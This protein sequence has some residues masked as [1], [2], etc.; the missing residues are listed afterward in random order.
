[1][2]TC[3]AFG[4]VLGYLGAGLGPLKPFWGPFELICDNLH[5]QFG[6]FQAGLGYFGTLS[7][8]LGHLGPFAG[9]LGRFRG[10]W[11]GLGT[12]LSAFKAIWGSLGWFF[13]I[14]GQFKLV[15]VEFFL[16]SN[17]A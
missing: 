9:N 5:G 13:A 4:G 11:G 14:F 16:P 10:T 12:L 17:G 8:A 2:G 7:V 15:L 3:G 1:M 6:A